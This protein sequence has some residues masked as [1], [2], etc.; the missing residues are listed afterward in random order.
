MRTMIAATLLIFS[1][2]AVAGEDSGFQFGF[3]LGKGTVDETV[4]GVPVD[5]SYFGWK[6]F[7]GYALNR[8]LSAELS[9][10]NGEGISKTIGDHKYR[11]DGESSQA[12]L[13]GSIPLGRDF[14][15]YG[16]AGMAK[17]HAKG[18]VSGPIDNGSDRD[19]GTD[20]YYGIGVSGPFDGALLRL[21]YEGGKFEETDVRLLSLSVVWMIR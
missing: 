1:G 12:S 17:W 6:L 19:D 14:S 7:A 10:S 2:A 15:I 4:F 11:L 5:S 16:R 8:Y 9:H 21:E 20:P 13:I 3:G 18:S